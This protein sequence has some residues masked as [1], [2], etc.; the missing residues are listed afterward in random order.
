MATSLPPSALSASIERFGVGKRASTA[1]THNGTGYFAV[2]PQSPYDGS[3]SVGEQTR[4]LLDKADARLAEIGT[5]KSRLLFVAI[6]LS[7][8]ADYAEM[9]TIWDAWIAGIP[10]PSRACFN[11][12]LASPEMKIEMIMISA[13]TDKSR[14]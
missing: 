7:D 10:P 4:Q 11:A 14:E 3:L 2:T 12:A 9:N 8:M 5:D 13:I 6:I 1:V